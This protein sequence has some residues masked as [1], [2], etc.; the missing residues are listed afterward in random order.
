MTS[1]DWKGVFISKFLLTS[2][3]VAL[4]A[5]S[6]ALVASGIALNNIEN[7][8]KISVNLEPISWLFKTEVALDQSPAPTNEIEIPNFKPV[9]LLKI[10]HPQKNNRK[11]KVYKKVVATN[12]ITDQIRE[13]R[14]APLHP[15]AIPVTTPHIEVAP[16]RETNADEGE[17]LRMQQIHKMIHMDFVARLDSIDQMD[18]IAMNTQLD[19]H[20]AAPA[21]NID[22]DQQM[23]IH[24]TTQAAPTLVMER[25]AAVLVAEN[26][27][28]SVAPVVKKVIRQVLKKVRAEKAKR[29]AQEKLENSVKEKIRDLAST[30]SE[31]LEKPKTIKFPKLPIAAEKP[32]YQAEK[33]LTKKVEETKPA[34]QTQVAENKMPE[35]NFDEHNDVPVFYPVTEQPKAEVKAEVQEPKKDS[36]IDAA[37]R[38]LIASNSVTTPLVINIPKWSE[39]SAATQPSQPAA[40]TIQIAP[41]P[42]VQA[43]PAVTPPV[44]VAV[45]TQPLLESKKE[46]LKNENPKDSKEPKK[47]DL[48]VSESEDQGQPGDKAEQSISWIPNDVA[49]AT[50]YTPAEKGEP[51]KKAATQYKEAFYNAWADEAVAVQ[52]N[53]LT[54]NKVESTGWK[55]A[56]TNTHWNTLYWSFSQG[57]EFDGAVPIIGNNTAR[58]LAAL[59]GHDIT[60]GTGIVFGRIAQGWKVQ[61]SG[62]SDKAVY[63][64]SKNQVVSAS[65]KTEGD[66]YF[67]ILNAA[68]GTHLVY[69]T[70]TNNKTEG[71][72]GV[73]VMSGHATFLDFSE[74]KRETLRGV[75]ADG[76]AAEFKGMKGV[77]VQV[78]GQTAAVAV[79]KKGGEFVIGN[80]V[81]MGAYPL[82]IETTVAKGFTY[83]TKLHRSP[84]Q[85]L[86]DVVLYQMS[87]Q[88]ITDWVNQLEGG[89]SPESALIISAVPTVISTGEEETLYPAT[90]AVLDHSILQP[91]T[92][93]VGV[94]GK[95][96]VGVPFTPATARA[97][98]VQVPEGPVI[99]M[100]QDKNGKT[101]W[102]ELV[103]ASPKVVNVVGPY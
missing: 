57:A 59:G 61:T 1:K 62:R 32:E 54:Y 36:A 26:T 103:I 94:D 83:R 16:A 28:V 8:P 21:Q 37:N 63:L 91:E 72:V 71:A 56:S 47:E 22:A 65:D 40:V 51:K 76:R 96:K 69:V 60:I 74:I 101:I 25:P 102:S 95:L 18:A 45:N 73:P 75:V 15:V 13:T 29:I 2:G 48:K 55:V 84:D 12:I 31:L 58:M 10:S 77:Q 11:N 4:T 52:V 3:T 82:H 7:E 9:A 42:V 68:P 23:D 14:A 97:L 98:S 81:T 86:N 53:N 50:T 99:H 43:P 41:A 39:Y 19:I 85:P 30:P 89:V 67:A 92:Y 34:E 17:M 24:V 87:D 33:N 27:E 70:D 6:I 100:V 20:D 79:T 46:E 44:T 38:L 78:A 5:T 80:V 90:K 93:T 88:Q 35:V 49:A 64:D 66:R